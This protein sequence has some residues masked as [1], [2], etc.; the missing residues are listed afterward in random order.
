[1]AIFARHLDAQGRLVPRQVVTTVM[2]NMGLGLALEKMGIAHET[3]AVG[4]RRVMEK[5]RSHGAI[6][7]GEDSGHIIFRDVHT[8]GD[9]ILSG[10]RLVQVMAETRRPLS[11]L[12]TVMSVLPQV[13][14]SVPVRSKPPIAELMAVAGEIA[15]VEAALAGE[16]RVLVRYSGTE[17]LCRVMVE[18]PSDAEA[19]RLCARIAKAIELAVGA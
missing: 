6:L 19:E 15:A 14:R 2:S 9:G 10:L 16:G 13:Q 3:S 4:D 5:M 18:G 7:G 1:M 17:P 12:A 8:T 11:A